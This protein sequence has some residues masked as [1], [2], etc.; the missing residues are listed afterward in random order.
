MILQKYLERE[1]I[2]K[3]YFFI[4]K[5][6]SELKMKTTEQPIRKRTINIL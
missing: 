1:G 5:I 4:D 2:F 6:Q 3:Q